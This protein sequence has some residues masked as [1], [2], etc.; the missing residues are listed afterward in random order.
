MRQPSIDSGGVGRSIRN[1]V[2]VRAEKNALGASRALSR[3]AVARLVAED[4][5][6]REVEVELFSRL[7]QHARFG[8]A[9]PAVEKVG[10][11]R[12]CGMVRAEVDAGE[13]KKFPKWSRFYVSRI[14]PLIILV[15]FVI[16]YIQKFSP[17]N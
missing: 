12:L 9:A 8:F 4:D 13:G 11:K 14:L 2:G 17:A 3:R 7:E 6:M 16:G 15:I 10:R 1:F 5:R